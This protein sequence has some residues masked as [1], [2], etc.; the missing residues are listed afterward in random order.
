MIEGFESAW[1]RFMD[2]S[3]GKLIEKSK[4]SALTPAA[5]KMAVKSAAGTWTDYSECGEWIKRLR[6]VSPE[7]ADAVLGLIDGISFEEIPVGTPMP[8]AAIPAAALGGSAVGVGLGSLLKWNTAGIILSAVIPAAILF[9]SLKKIKSLQ[10]EYNRDKLIN[11]YME[12][13]SVLKQKIIETV[14]NKF[15]S[16]PRK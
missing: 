9:P 2:L 4:Q 6:L 5:A 3:M 8:D 12:Q 14:D 16:S 11:G 10:T 15:Y 13:L 7:K 1:N